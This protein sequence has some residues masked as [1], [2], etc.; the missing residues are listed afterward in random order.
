MI[1]PTQLLYWNLG[2]KYVM[3]KGMTWKNLFRN[4]AEGHFHASRDLE[5]SMGNISI[6]KMEGGMRL[7]GAGGPWYS[8]DY[9]QQGQ[10][11]SRRVNGGQFLTDRRAEEQDLAAGTV[12]GQEDL[13]YCGE[14]GHLAS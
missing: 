13:C 5:A 8:V 4:Q 2:K 6:G 1:D 10:Y 14:L 9:F 3:Q 11:W 7:T 12:F